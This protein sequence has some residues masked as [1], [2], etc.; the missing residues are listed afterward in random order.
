MKIL[1]NSIWLYSAEVIARLLVALLLVIVARKL[2]ATET[3]KYVFVASL[4]TIA[5]SVA[6]FGSTQYYIRTAIHA[7]A[8]MRDRLFWLVTVFRLVLTVLLALLM[9]AY[10]AVITEVEVR[11]LLLFAAASLPIGA[12]PGVVVAALRAQERMSFEAVGKVLVALLTLIG[13]GVLVLQG[14]GIV[15]LGAVGV[16][17]AVAGLVYYLAVPRGV[18][19]A[20]IPRILRLNDLRGVAR[21]AWPFFSVSILV[22]IYSR[23]DTLLLQQLMG[24]RAVGQ[25]GVAVRVMEVLFVIPFVLGT[26]MFPSIARNLRAHPAMVLAQGL[27]G[28][29]WLVLASLPI[30]L[31]GS[32]VGPAFFAPI[33]GQEFAAS[34]PAFQILVWTVVPVFASVVTSSIIAASATPIVNTYL[35]AGM[36]LLNLVANLVLIPRYGISGAAA[37]R[38]ATEWLGLIGGGIYI[39][40]RIAPLK[41]LP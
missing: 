6:D 23:L 7:D 30:A 41:G 5:N 34:G 14:F 19:S 13:G 36:V 18:L 28:I 31:A 22:V 37:V 9:A 25:Y 12:I 16:G 8:S 40:A 21:G 38:L 4:T 10:A 32:L 27:K 15:S 17:A 20:N 39:A 35:A 3:G 33:F 2:G 29:R 24:P 26:A 1:R 11:A